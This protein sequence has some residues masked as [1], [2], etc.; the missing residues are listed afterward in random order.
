MTGTKRIWGTLDP[1]FE[2]GPILGR[3]VANTAFLDALLRADPYDEYH[4]F[5]PG[6]RALA[7]LKKHLEAT[8]PGLLESARVRLMLRDELPGR[9][10]S[11]HYHCFHLSD[12]ITSQPFLAR[13]RNRLSERIFPIT[14]PIHSLSYAG[15]PKAF[16]QHLWPG[17][18]RRDAIVCTSEAGKRVVEGFFR[19]LREGFG[20][21]E[22]TH[23]GPTLSRIPLGVDAE[24]CS[25]GDGPK[26][27][28]VRI[29]VFGR[30][31]HHSKM[32]LVPLV[33]ALHRLVGDGLD[34]QSVE[35][36]L[37][38]WAERET[39]VLDT[40]TNLAAN[41]G[42]P[43][44]V[45]LR[46]GEARKRE[47]FRKADIFVS[48]ADNPQETF[49]IT[50]VE[51][52]AF[53]LP[54]AASDYDG[55][56]DI[57]EHGVTGLLIPTMGPGLTPDVD[58]AAPLT[59]DNHYHL[60]L[61]QATAVDVPALA[62]ALNRLIRDPELRRSMGIAGR[63]RVRRL[64][65][66]PVVIARY[67]ALWDDLWTE[68]VDVA[69]L[70]DLAHPLAPEYGRLFAHYPTRTLEGGVRLVIGRTGE[71]FYRNRD[72]PNVY[73]GLKDAIDLETIR[74]LAFFARK[75]VDSATLIRK[76]SEATPH[77]D[78]GR[79]E[80]HILWALKQDILQTTE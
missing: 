67:T 51:A 10:E 16:L 28:P 44:S 7:P 33:R 19:Q 57:V 35:L 64:F 4:F 60:A 75:P 31:S 58:L 2:G 23:P 24:D 40:L 77:M 52:G 66:W 22:T 54:V 25:P 74:R 36:I 34:P 21:D 9:L 48:I 8:T 56:R 72:F 38:G 53:G 80:N 71:A 68:P 12:C 47:L 63:E 45:V 30:I 70:R 27:G 62:D 69:P 37:A 41:A 18:T 76:A 39:H 78:S 43:T 73:A 14:G 79:I 42:I 29:L 1:F 46:P 17:A 6:E 26:E 59:F 61:A 13:M 65:D 15:Y 49:G 3:T 55:Y 20:I 5:L 11:T 50:L 32:D